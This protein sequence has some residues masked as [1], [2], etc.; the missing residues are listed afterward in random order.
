HKAGKRLSLKYELID[1]GDPRLTR[2]VWRDDYDCA[3]DDL[4]TRLPATAL[5]IVEE[6]EISLTGEERKNLAKRPTDVPEAYR[7]YGLGRREW[8][9]VDKEGYL[10]SIDYYE[11]AIAVDPRFALAYSGIADSY[12]MIGMTHGPPRK[13]MEEGRKWALEAIKLDKDLV[14]SRLSLAI[15]H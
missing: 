1:I 15:Y 10:R 13:Y 9:R 14:E 12:M 3:E 5:R 7:L 8:N 11:R 2:V 6:L 4:P